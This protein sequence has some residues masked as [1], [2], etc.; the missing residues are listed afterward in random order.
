MNTAFRTICIIAVLITFYGCNDSVT[1]ENRD[2]ELLSLNELDEH[3]EIGLIAWRMPGG[4]TGGSAC[5]HC[6]APDGL[7][8]AYLNYSDFT[9]RRRGAE[10]V[11]PG[12][13]TLSA[14][15]LEDIVNMVRALQ[16]KHNIDLVNPRESIPFQPGGNVLQGEDNRG[17]DQAFAKVIK[18]SSF[19]FTTVAIDSKS[20]ALRQL[21]E[22]QQLPVSDI[23]IGIE[24]NHWSEDP[25][26]SRSVRILSDWVPAVSIKPA[27]NDEEEWLGL[28]INY[29]N[30]P[31][32]R[33]LANLLK[34]GSLLYDVSEIGALSEL[35][36]LK[37][38]AL[39]IAQHQFREAGTVEQV[40]KI[41]LKNS[42]RDLQQY[43][44]EIKN[45]FW[46]IGVFFDRHPSADYLDLPE[47]LMRGFSE[48][49]TAELALP[50]YW[51][52][53][54]AY[55]TFEFTDC[56]DPGGCLAVI[57]DRL[58]EEGFHFHRVFVVAKTV[59]AMAMED[60]WYPFEPATQDQ[61]V[62]S[63]ETPE[64]QKLYE[65]ITENLRLMLD[66]SASKK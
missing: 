20:E 65:H 56:D 64:L 5:V 36:R 59:A 14:S 18:A 66:Y 12:I 19:R 24:L 34:Y 43:Y 17:R 49:N 42:I 15:K 10:H 48:S 51:L 61:P 32:N 38:K 40:Q 28:Q 29:T 3:I 2:Y 27:I 52:G 7:D 6:H 57:S 31:G 4:I 30:K 25:Y 39:L 62:P 63:F 1:T 60:K 23:P 41:T 8:L 21:E 26:Y 44:P 13:E 58:A 11:S 35:S 47:N 37:Y 55:P 45:P 33:E 53:W 22:W 46:E 54:M 16:V 9:L 50:W